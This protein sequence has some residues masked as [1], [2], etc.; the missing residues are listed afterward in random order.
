MAERSLMPVSSVTRRDAVL[1][2]L[3][4]AILNGKLV[5]GDRLKE[6]QLSQE[7]GVSRPTLREAIYQLIH[8]GLL[9]QEAYKGVTVASID[10]ATINDIAVVRSSLEIIAA[11]AIAADKNGAARV[12]LQK[13]WDEYED[14]AAS[15]DRARENAA[16]L[17]LHETIWM[18][19]G[20]VMLQRIWP[21]VSASVNLA[22]STDDAVRHDDER[23]RRMHREL[24]R[25]ILHNHQRGI[26]TAVRN[27]IQTSAAELAEILKERR[28]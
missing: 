8:E 14:A 16:H 13:A 5:P 7:L 1:A 10:A 9:V 27:H 25:A 6:V 28:T 4:S 15:G 20:N 26:T 23:N 22:L 21:I 11:K 18:E 3:R 17:A 2:E 24:V 19:S 12:A